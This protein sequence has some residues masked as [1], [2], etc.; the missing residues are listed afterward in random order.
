MSLGIATNRDTRMHVSNPNVCGIAQT[1]A[2]AWRKAARSLVI[3]SPHSFV[4]C[5]F[6]F[7]VFEMTLR[8]RTSM[9]LTMQEIQGNSGDTAL[10]GNRT[11]AGDELTM[12]L[13]NVA[14]IGFGGFAIVECG[15][16]HSSAS[17]R[18][19]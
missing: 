12:E 7:P 9:C 10:F 17:A 19:N 14:A 8:K 3:I 1:I 4:T 6:I 13:A 2:I 18:G 5:D 11:A 15:P 16:K